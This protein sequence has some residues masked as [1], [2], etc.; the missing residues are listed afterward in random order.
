M[1]HDVAPDD[2]VVPAAGADVGAALGPASEAERLEVQDFLFREA[3]LLDEDRFEDWLGLFAAEC[4]Y[5]LPLTRDQANGFDAISLIFDDRRL[6]ETRIKRVRHAWFHAQTPNSRLMHFV[7]NVTADRAEDGFVARSMHL[8]AEHRV[9][10]LR[11]YHASVTHQL[12]RRG[13][14][15]EMVSNRVDLIDSEGEHRGIAVLL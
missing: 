9:N 3:R 12:R 1:P 6:L 8:I 2:V 7:T 14:S 4:F 15:F 5:W 11:E 10:R 13:E